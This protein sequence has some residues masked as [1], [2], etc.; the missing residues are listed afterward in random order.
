MSKLKAQKRIEKIKKEK[1]FFAYHITGL[2]VAIGE[3][4]FVSFNEIGIDIY[5]CGCEML[6]IHSIKQENVLSIEVSNDKEKIIVDSKKSV[7][8]RTIFGYAILGGIGAIMGGASAMLPKVKK[9]D[10]YIVEIITK[11]KNIIM[12]IEEEKSP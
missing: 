11:K 1:S 7:L 2:D 4:C 6:L 12:K 8:W 5:S 9:Q 10:F 3:E